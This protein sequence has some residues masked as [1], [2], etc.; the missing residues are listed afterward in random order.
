M[1]FLVSFLA[2]G[3]GP[4]QHAGSSEKSCGQEKLSDFAC[5]GFLRL[6]ESFHHGI[7]WVTLG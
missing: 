2:D 7:L 5:S 1:H 6:S 3:H 4:D